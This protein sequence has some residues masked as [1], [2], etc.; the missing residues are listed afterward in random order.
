MNLRNIVQLKT[1]T[2]KGNLDQNIQKDQLKNCYIYH[3]R[4]Q[5]SQSLK[6]VTNPKHKFNLAQSFLRRMK[7]LKDQT[8]VQMINLSKLIPIQI[9]RSHQTTKKSFYLWNLL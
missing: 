3:K 9:V 4:N 2:I 8:E 5:V 6:I 7:T 1:K